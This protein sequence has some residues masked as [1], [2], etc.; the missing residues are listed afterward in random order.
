MHLA[1]LGREMYVLGV[2]QRQILLHGNDKS[3]ACGEGKDNMREQRASGSFKPPSIIK[4][5]FF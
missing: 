4:K 2:I 5:E 3:L 1:R